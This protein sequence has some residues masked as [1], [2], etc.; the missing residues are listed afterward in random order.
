[1][2]TDCCVSTRRTTRRFVRFFQKVV[3]SPLEAL[4]QE[5]TVVR[6]HFGR[7]SAAKGRTLCSEEKEEIIVLYAY[8]YAFLI[9][10]LSFFLCVKTDHLNTD[11]HGF[12]CENLTWMRNSDTFFRGCEIAGSSNEN[13][14]LAGQETL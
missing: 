6:H 7:L 8:L 1:M 13:P 11:R 5:G 4:L 14:K 12:G 2:L 9:E 3:D 10:L